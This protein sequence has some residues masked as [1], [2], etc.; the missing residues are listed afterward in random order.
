MKMTTRIA[1]ENMKYYRSRNILI[2]IATFLTTLLLFVIPTVAKDII[3]QDHAW[4]K[5][6]TPAWYGCF[7]DIDE[8]MVKNLSAHK[9]IGEWGL[10]CEAGRVWSDAKTENQPVV[11]LVYYDEKGAKL[12]KKELAEGRMPEQEKEIAVSGKCLEELGISAAVGDEIALPVQILRK[13]VLDYREEQKF[14]VTGFLTDEK[15]YEVL[16][17]DAFI[18]KEIPDR[19]YCF[20]FQIRGL[21]NIN[22]DDVEESIYRIADGFSIPRQEVELNNTYLNANYVDPDFLPIV[23]V[24]MCIV[25]FA[26]IIAIYNIYYISMTQR[27]RE[28]GRLKA[29]GTT[30]KQLKQILLREGLLIAGIAIPAGLIAGTPLIKLLL[31][32]FVRLGMNPYKDVDMSRLVF[33]AY[34]NIPIYHG[35]IYLMAAGISLFTVC[36]SL[37]VPLHKAGKISV[38]ETL[39]FSGANRK[40]KR[41]KLCGRLSVFCLAKINLS[42]NRK[43]GL[44]T[45]LSMSMTGILIMIVASVLSCASP[46]QMTDAL[47]SG[48]YEISVKVENGNR[49]HPE[50][51]WES[52]KKNNP[53]NADLKKKIENLGGVQKIEQFDVLT[54]T[55]D[56]FD[57]ES[58][59]WGVPE[60]YAH[61]L[62]AGLIE[63]KADYEDLQSGDKVILNNLF[64][65]WNPEVQLAVGDKVTL[66]VEGKKREF[67]IIGIG[68]YNG[69]YCYGAFLMAKEPVDKMVPDNTE[70]FWSI[71]A[72]EVYNAELYAKLTALTADTG[73]MSIGAW[74]WQ[75]DGNKAALSMTRSA[76]II[77]LGVLG[78]I[79]ITNLINTM[80]Q[81]VNVRR[82]EIGMLQAVGMSRRQLRNMLALEGMYYTLG[83]LLV[84]L[85]LGSILGYWAFLWG[86]KAGLLAIQ[87]FHYPWQAAGI[88]ALVLILIQIVLVGTLSSFISRENVTERIR[89]GG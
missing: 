19:R 84:S 78:V 16:V 4:V 11:G 64:L 53:L 47:F 45:I 37:A 74:K 57:G 60:A 54:V 9:D 82:K 32:C 75:Y 58:D 22:K 67:E 63:G 69:S 3:D 83:A 56:F 81:S 29:L 48:Q 27:T 89:F 35:W 70:R 10:Y 52:V 33:D 42:D 21:D 55:G 66:Q 72:D 26:G 50:W 41:R 80:I 88:M 61:E 68:E 6:Y 17:S 85:G 7:Q 40:E 13:G 15:P 59:L 87:T 1:M 38:V 39:R 2:G 65:S 20:A 5:E 30:K 86:K 24:I 28:L 25:V 51:Q 8:D 71:Y 14:T 76:C 62:K 43:K 31:Y 73:K 46:E 79:C 44:I 34:M 77:F 23:A 49:E 36:L 18:K 12:Y